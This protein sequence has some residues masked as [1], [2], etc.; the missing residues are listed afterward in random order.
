MPFVAGVVVSQAAGWVRD[1]SQGRVEM[2]FATPVS[3]ARLVVGRLVA[4]AVASGAVGAGALV[5]VLVGKAWSGVPLDALGLLPVG[6]TCLLLGLG[7]A[8][9]AILVVAASPAPSP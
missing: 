7:L 8:G 5:G 4:A 1:L 2:I 3:S 6:A 9:V